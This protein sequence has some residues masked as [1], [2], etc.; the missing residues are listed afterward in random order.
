MS[1]CTVHIGRII[2]AARTVLTKPSFK[3]SNHLTLCIAFPSA[4]NE[5]VTVNNG[6]RN[7]SII[8]LSPGDSDKDAKMNKRKKRRWVYNFM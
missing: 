8:Y 5:I 3:K 6:T 7:S 1:P 2:G 4:A